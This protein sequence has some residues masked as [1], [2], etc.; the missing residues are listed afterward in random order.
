[1]IKAGHGRDKSGTNGTNGTMRIIGAGTNGTLPLRGVPVSQLSGQNS[2]VQQR[3]NFDHRMADLNDQ[4]LHARRNLPRCYRGL[5]VLPDMELRL[6][7]LVEQVKRADGD[8][9]CIW[10]NWKTRK[11]DTP[12]PHWVTGNEP[13]PAMPYQRWVQI[14][15]LA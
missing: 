12:V 15:E 4:T 5:I 9:W 6:V 7:A 1:M 14:M 3:F 13:K 2:E 8:K 10:S 11:G